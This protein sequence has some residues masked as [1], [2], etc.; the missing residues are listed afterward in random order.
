MS[1]DFVLGGQRHHK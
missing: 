1:V